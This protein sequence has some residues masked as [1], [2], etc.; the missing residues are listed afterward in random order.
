MQKYSKETRGILWTLVFCLSFPL[1][2]AVVRHLTDLGMPSPQIVFMRNISAVLLLVPFIFLRKEKLDL[3][4]RNR[5][6]YFLRIIFGLTSM[7]LWFY[8]LGRL[9][10]ATAT[11][12]SFSTP[13]F[14]AL[15]AVIFLKEKMGLRRWSAVAIG[16]IGTIIIL[17]P[18]VMDFNL[19]AASVLGG[20]LFMSIALI[21]VKKLTNT[22]TPFNMMFHMHLWMGVF[23]IPLAFINWQVLNLNMVLWCVA[24]SVF[25]I[26]G[27]YALARAYTLVEVT[28]TLP[29]DFT[30]LI[31]ASIVAYYAF[32]ETPDIYTYIGA[33]IIICSSIFIAHR[34][35][36]LRKMLKEE[37]ELER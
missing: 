24:L 26:T 2:T 22:E 3:K 8:G 20:C 7:M 23:S 37:M 5:N 1:L 30:R 27:Q 6:L 35:A 25:S 29:F 13:I 10:L 34:E 11:A 21:I 14:A 4:I 32:A 36:R 9:P 33:G 18:G 15:M 16:F 12:L 19:A 31:I 28:L 17:R